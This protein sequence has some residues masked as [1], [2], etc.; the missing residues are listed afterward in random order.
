MKKIWYIVLV[1]TISQHI[2]FADDLPG[3]EK[4]EEI[5]LK[6]RW[7]T[8]NKNEQKLPISQNI[9]GLAQVALSVTCLTNVI[10]LLD[11]YGNK[12]L[13]Y[14]ELAT[15]GGSIKALCLSSW[16]ASLLY[17]SAKL[18][19]KA[20]KSLTNTEEKEDSPDEKRDINTLPKEQQKS[21]NR[22]R[23]VA[24]CALALATV[25]SSGSSL[26]V[27]LEQLCSNAERSADFQRVYASFSL[28]A[29]IASCIHT[30]TLACSALD[31]INSPNKKG[32]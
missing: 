13:S 3:Q 23:G 26:F 28:G 17:S 19:Q 15:P 18:G 8:I 32:H 12:W 7:N 29:A 27:L 4:K 22:A 21:K 25:L 20:A 24:K 14:K 16:I 6:Q 9:L 2:V 10:C 1:L 30:Y 11:F 31:S 5:S